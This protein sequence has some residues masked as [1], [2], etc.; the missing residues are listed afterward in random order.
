MSDFELVP[1][2]SPPR[3]GKDLYI[4]VKHG[5]LIAGVYLKQV[6]QRIHIAHYDL[7]QEGHYQV[8]LLYLQLQDLVL[9][10]YLPYQLLRVEI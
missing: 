8:L 10:L 2:V 3:H 9:E 4:R 7:I 6:F 1:V 5:V